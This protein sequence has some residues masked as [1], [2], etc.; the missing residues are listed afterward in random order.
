MGAFGP[1]VDMGLLNVGVIMDAYQ[2]VTDRIVQALEDGVIPWR[3]PWAGGLSPNNPVTGSVY[4][5]INTVLL[6]CEKQDD[7]RWTTFKGAVSKGYSVKGCKGKG[8]PIVFWKMN[9]YKSK[10]KVT[11]EEELKTFPFMRTYTVFNYEDLG[12]TP[13]LVVEARDQVALHAEA[14]TIIDNSGA[15]VRHGGSQ[16]YYRPSEDF[17]QLPPREAFDST[18][19]YYGT[20]LHEMAHWTGADGRVARNLKGGFGTEEYAREELR[21]EIASAFTCSRYQLERVDDTASYL[22]SWLRKL[23]E[24]KHEIVRASTDAKKITEYLVQYAEARAEAAG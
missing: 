9:R 15:D 10:D 8:V 3:K 13:D 16:A 5:G 6:G 11:G 23:K 19:A 14:Q 18:S 17:I 20:A 22:A 7:P 1:A 12:G 4:T 21:A 2:K 24:D